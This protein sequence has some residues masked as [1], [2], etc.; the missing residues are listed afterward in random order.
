LS[1]TSIIMCFTS[2]IGFFIYLVVQTRLNQIA[3]V[4]TYITCYVLFSLFIYLLQPKFYNRALKM[5]IDAFLLKFDKYNLYAFFES[6]FFLQVLI[7]KNIGY[8][9]S[10]YVIVAVMVLIGKKIFLHVF[11][12][13]TFGLLFLSKIFE[14]IVFGLEYLTNLKTSGVKESQLYKI[15]LG[16]KDE[17]IN[18]ENMSLN[19]NKLFEFSAL[20]QSIIKSYGVKLRTF[21]GS[22]YLMS[23]ASG[24]V[25]IIMNKAFQSTGLAAGIFAGTEIYKI[26]REQDALAAKRKFEAEQ[27]EKNRQH[28]TSENAEQRRWKTEENEKNRRAYADAE[29]RKSNFSALFGRKSNGSGGSNNKGNVAVDQIELSN[30]TTLQILE[31]ILGNSMS[32]GA[33]FLNLLIE[34]IRKLFKSYIR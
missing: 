6:T 23:G 30:N 8:L 7:R 24:N 22:S 31:D 9:F 17:T 33:I 15:L 14:I 20:G 26:K 21:S 34:L 19:Q 4:D 2:F 5:I 11:M 25:R 16:M 1:K 3:G 10:V 27:A 18:K 28:Q 32:Q 12:L 13:F 29:E